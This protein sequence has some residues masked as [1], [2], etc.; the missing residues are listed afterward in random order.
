MRKIVLITLFAVLGLGLWGQESRADEGHNA[1]S[2]TLW[3]VIFNNPDACV[4]NPGGAEQCG[5]ADVF[6]QAFLDSIASG[7]PNPS[8]IAPNTDAG[9]GVLFATGGVTGENGRI[10]LAASIY[11][12]PEGGGLQLAAAES[13]VDP[14]GLGAGLENP[15]AEIHLV[16][17]DHGRRVRRGELQQI[18]G[19]LDPYCS[20]PNLLYFAGSNTC[21]DVQFAVFGPGESGPDDVYAFGATPEKVW[22][23]RATLIR[24]GDAVQAFV[25]TRLRGGE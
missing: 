16:V 14:L 25:E 21:A 2:V 19:F 7:A 23:A 8:L 13:I 6:G 24:N 17:R 20:D 11:R 15:Q 10:S 4:A 1:R 22:R 18:S 12:S 9:L 5:G 3:W